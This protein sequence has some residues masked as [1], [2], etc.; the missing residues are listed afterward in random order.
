MLFIASHGAL[1]RKLCPSTMAFA[2]PVVSATPLGV[3]F[4][5]ICGEFSKILLRVTPKGVPELGLAAA[6]FHERRSPFSHPPFSLY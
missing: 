5:K 4:P 2:V 6:V 3:T 1:E